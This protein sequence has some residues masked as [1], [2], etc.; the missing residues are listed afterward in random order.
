MD[1]DHINIDPVNYYVQAT[2]D[3]YC[4]MGNPIKNLFKDFHDIKYKTNIFGDVEMNLSNLNYEE[5]NK[6]INFI[7]NHKN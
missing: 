3:G 2:N 6:L 1:K 7:E 4:L 5:K